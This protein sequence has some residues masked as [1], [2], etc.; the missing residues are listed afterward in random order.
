L[1]IPKAQH[2][3]PWFGRF[4][5]DKQNKTTHKIDLPCFIDRSVAFNAKLS[6]IVH[7][8]FVKFHN[9]INIMLMNHFETKCEL[10]NVK[11]DNI[12]SNKCIQIARNKN[13]HLVSTNENWNSINDKMLSLLV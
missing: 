4:Q 12:M 13:S 7:F 1:K 10:E 9:K 3:T 8:L 6:I 11:N 5:R 2:E